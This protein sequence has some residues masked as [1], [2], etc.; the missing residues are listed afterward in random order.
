MAGGGPYR[1]AQLSRQ[2]PN[3]PAIRTSAG[4]HMS[5]AE[6]WQASE[7]IAAHVPKSARLSAAAPVRPDEARGDGAPAAGGDVVKAAAGRCGC[8]RLR[9]G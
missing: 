1:A 5:Y 6:L 2:V 9:S 4:E 8:I 3:T 7:A